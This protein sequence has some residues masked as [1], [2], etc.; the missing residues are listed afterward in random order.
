MAPGLRGGITRGRSTERS[1]PAFGA[2]LVALW[3]LL[4]CLFPLATQASPSGTYEGSAGGLALGIDVL[5]TPSTPQS[6]SAGLSTAAAKSTPFATGKGA[7]TCQTG[8]PSSV[9]PANLPCTSSANLANAAASNIGQVDDP[10][11][12]CSPGIPEPLA[13]VLGPAF[14]LDTACG[15]A[16][17]QIVGTDPLGEGEGSVGLLSVA[18]NLTGLLPQAEDAK[19]EIVKTIN[20]LI[21]PVIE[22]F[23][24]EAKSFYNALV[25]TL[26]GN[27][28]A[29]ALKIGAT[30]SSVATT[31]SVLTAQATAEGG[32][33]GILGIPVCNFP[34]GQGANTEAIA[35]SC[36]PTNPDPITDGLIII[37]ISKASSEAKWD[38]AAAPGAGA[39]A[40]SKAAVVSI[41]VRDLT[42]PTT[43]TYLPPVEITQSAPLPSPLFAGLPVQTSITVNGATT[44]VSNDPAPAQKGSASAQSGLVQIHALQGLGATSA[45][46]FDGGLRI[47]VVVTEANAKGEVP[48]PILNL[49]KTGGMRVLFYSLAA[50]LVVGAPLTFWFSR[51]LRN[52][53]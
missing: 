53:P 21:E 23:P 14:T 3:V 10:A 27:Q 34:S 18:V 36:T 43:K 35:I 12:I 25:G 40:S 30:K 45:T 33:I 31:G 1:R 39:A 46:A 13:S 44:S 15:D 5:L 2:E 24:D 28:K 48:A 20:D 52:S 47:R 9:T 37:N 4:F 22:Q 41:L 11:L 29:L 51:R 7:G 42:K 32:T 38:A 26:T 50:L 19:D 49:P 17:A 16:K 8:V 6:F